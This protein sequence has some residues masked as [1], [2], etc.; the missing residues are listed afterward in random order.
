MR[1]FA[2]FGLGIFG[3]SIAIALYQQGF[4]VLG[5]DIDEDPVKEMAG[6]I[7]EVVQA[8]T[9]DERVL[10]ALGVRNFDVAIVSIGNDIQSSVLTTLAVKE[11]GVPFIVA[12]AINEMHGKI[13]EKIGADR[14]IFPERDMAL[15]VAKTLAFPNAIRTEELFP[16]YNVVEVKLPP[17]FHGVSLGKAQLRNRYG[18]TVLAIK[19]DNEYRVSPSAD[20]VLFKGDIIYILGNEQQLRRFFRETIESRNGKVVEV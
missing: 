1:Q 20:E 19:R 12:R 17:V 11:L 6:K 9:T 2:V 5:V 16:G 3:S 8:D 15:R 10:E 13:L 14:V 4:T 18:I 7:T